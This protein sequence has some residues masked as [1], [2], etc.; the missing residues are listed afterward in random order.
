MTEVDV[1]SKP[2][3]ELTP[4]SP[5]AVVDDFTPLVQVTQAIGVYTG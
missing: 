4:F 2:G 3:Q 1:K 5:L